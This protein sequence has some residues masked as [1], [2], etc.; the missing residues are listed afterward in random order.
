MKKI[1]NESIKKFLLVTLSKYSESVSLDSL[2]TDVFTTEIDYV[3]FLLQV[4]NK[5]G[6]EI[7]DE[8]AMSF[9]TINDIVK[10]YYEF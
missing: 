7:H 3:S 5:L 1:S 2:I 8:N 4:E 9:E 10:Y 6:I